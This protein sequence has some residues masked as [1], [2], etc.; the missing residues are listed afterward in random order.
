MSAHRDIVQRQDADITQDDVKIYPNSLW[1]LYDR[2]CQAFYG[3]LPLE[4]LPGNLKEVEET[5]DKLLMHHVA[6]VL[7]KIGPQKYADLVRESMSNEAWIIFLLRCVIACS[8]DAPP[9]TIEIRRNKKS[10]GS[11][12]F[13]ALA[14]AEDEKKKQ[15]FVDDDGNPIDIGSIDVSDMFEVIERTEVKQERTQRDRMPKT[16]LTSVLEFLAQ[17][18]IDASDI[19]KAW[20]ELE[21]RWRP[22]SIHEKIVSRVAY[23]IVNS[24]ANSQS[25]NKVE[26][27]SFHKGSPSCEMGRLSSG[28]ARTSG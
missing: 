21:K 4:S 24:I 10:I 27:L 23:L 14:K 13:A 20:D 28:K 7:R 16:L 19:K 2:I 17:E 6:E 25:A 5:A 3:S 9:D 1:R 26:L 15:E 22:V 8:D 12:Q 18:G 11:L